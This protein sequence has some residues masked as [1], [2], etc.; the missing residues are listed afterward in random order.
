MSMQDHLR[1]G[2]GGVTHRWLLT[3]LTLAVLL[4]IGADA[5]GQLLAGPQPGD[6]D[7]LGK[8]S[9]YTLFP[10]HELLA[11]LSHDPNTPGTT[12]EFSFNSFAPS[13]DL[14]TLT[15]IGGATNVLLD[16]TAPSM[17]A[18]AGRIL[19]ADKD[20]VVYARRAGINTI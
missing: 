11:V 2:S 18:G 16:P 4:T 14:K 1:Q 9:R 3:V 12:P 6:D 8:P 7:P 5:F 10:D 13:A 20:Q 19:A 15:P 17:V